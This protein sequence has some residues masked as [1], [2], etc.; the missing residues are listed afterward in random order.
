MFNQRIV[1]K[2]NFKIIS[3]AASEV[4]LYV[5]ILAASYVASYF[6]YSHLS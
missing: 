4:I 6:A 1:E 2:V 3:W 5:L